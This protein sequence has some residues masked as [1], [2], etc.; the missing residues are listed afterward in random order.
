MTGP[1]QPAAAKCRPR[2]P[3]AILADFRVTVK[4]GG[5]LKRF[6]PDEA[7]VHGVLV[8]AMAGH[9]SSMRTI[10]KILML[11]DAPMQARRVVKISF[12]TTHP[13]SADEALQILGI[14]VK[15]DDRTREDGGPYLKIEPWFAAQALARPK[16]PQ[17]DEREKRWLH[18]DVRIEGGNDADWNPA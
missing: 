16:A 2:F 12:A 14:A 5:R 9:S 4:S 8:D 15:C 17:L 7:A 10:A 3:Y 6:T 11:R 13:A 18:Q 1:R